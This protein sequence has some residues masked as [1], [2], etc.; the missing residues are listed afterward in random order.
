MR[1]TA[2][3]QVGELLRRWQ[4]L[5]DI[6]WIGPPPSATI[7][8]T[9]ALGRLLVNPSLRRAFAASP[10]DVARR[11]A[12]RD[13]DIEA[14]AALDAKALEDQARMLEE[15]KR[16]FR[17]RRTEIGNAATASFIARQRTQSAV[18]PTRRCRYRLPSLSLS[19]GFATAEQESWLRP[20]LAHLE[21]D[22]GADTDVTIDLVQDRCGTVVEI[23]GA[24]VGLCESLDH[25]A[26]EILV[27]LRRIVT[28]RTG[29]FLQFHA[30]VVST[31]SRCLLMPAAQGSGKTTLTAALARSGFR[32]FTDE[33]A[34]LEE[35]TLDA[36]AVPLP[37]TVKP[38]SV[39]PLAPYYPEL[40]DL[41]L[42]FRA[43]EQEIRYLVP[44]PE[45]RCTAD[46][47]PTPIRWIVFPRYAPDGPTALRAIDKAEAL[48]RLMDECLAV[49][50]DL[51]RANVGALIEWLRGVDCFELPMSS[52]ADAVNLLQGLCLE[53]EER[54]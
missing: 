2:E 13:T 23:E 52:L 54:E 25:L 21:G 7:D 42:Q 34:L 5:G 16:K 45:G 18:R 30:G 33:I 49:R 48:R 39:A 11:L 28:D 29:F 12:L 20:P 26:R 6:D 24:A 50:R 46:E 41:P 3:T 51:D 22:A 9:T 38:G 27:L 44:R 17:D 37:L 47:P 19:I 1:Q 4:G 31:G 8:L 15:K 36:L 10:H 43:D 40:L 32:Y 35:A 53:E 14:F